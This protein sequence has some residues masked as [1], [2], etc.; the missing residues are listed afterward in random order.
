M[1]VCTVGDSGMLRHWVG[2]VPQDNLRGGPV[3]FFE[4]LEIPLVNKTGY[5]YNISSRHGG[6]GLVG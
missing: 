2:V 4:K 3:G 5:P 1:H 6:C